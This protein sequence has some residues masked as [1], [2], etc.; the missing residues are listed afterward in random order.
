V[1]LTELKVF[2]ATEAVYELCMLINR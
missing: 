2:F 1:I